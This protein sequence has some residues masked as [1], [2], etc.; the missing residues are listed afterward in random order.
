MKIEIDIINLTPHSIEYLKADGKILKFPSK[1]Q[2][3]VRTQDYRS[4]CLG[5]IRFVNYDS[6]PSVEGLPEPSHGKLYI[7]STVVQTALKNRR[8]DLL[9]P[10]MIEK[11]RDGNILCCR[12]FKL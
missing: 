9:S 5:D 2:A 6:E 7:V 4:I 3:R 10:C 11:D 8:D 1:G 12:A